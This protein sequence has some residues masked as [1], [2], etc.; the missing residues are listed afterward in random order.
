MS[1]KINLLMFLA[2]LSKNIKLNIE[3]FNKK[4]STDSEFEGKVTGYFID[5]VVEAI[6]EDFESNPKAVNAFS[7]FYLSIVE[8]LYMNIHDD[9]VKYALLQNIV[10]TSYLFIGYL[11]RNDSLE[12]AKK[13]SCIKSDR[14]M[15]GHYISR[16]ILTLS[17][18]AGVPSSQ[19]GWFIGNAV[20]IAETNN[21][22]GEVF[23]SNK[24]TILA[25][26][27]QADFL[28]YYFEYREAEGDIYAGYPSFL[29]YSKKN[30]ET[31]I[32]K[33]NGLEPDNGELNE[34]VQHVRQI[35]SGEF[36]MNNRWDS[37]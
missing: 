27:C 3:H 22:L 24:D 34:M 18:R 17:A 26:A 16:S 2:D 31:L 1:Q 25:Y 12:E 33:L 8:N 19:R 11:I 7:D 30:I 37:K 23:F 9:Q 36:F 10:S 15:E 14:L 4:N 5:A 6:K 35:R 13:I 28:Q 21:K 32:T 29:F 20:H